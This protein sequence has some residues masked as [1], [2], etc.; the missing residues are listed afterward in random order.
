[1]VLIRSFGSKIKLSIKH[2]NK[3]DTSQ[4]VLQLKLTST[5]L[6]LQT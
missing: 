4:L 1:M 5:K 2:Q 3:Y 6:M